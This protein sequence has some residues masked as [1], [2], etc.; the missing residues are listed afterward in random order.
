MVECH[1]ESGGDW[2]DERYVGVV[3]ELVKSQSKTYIQT[4]ST[5]NQEEPGFLTPFQYDIIITKGDMEKL[6]P[7]WCNIGGLKLQLIV[8]V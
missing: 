8:D 4:K 6:S 1:W 3:G 7:F 2:Y 5:I